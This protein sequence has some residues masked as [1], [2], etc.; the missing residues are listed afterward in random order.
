M[1][2]LEGRG[3]A[4]R[5][6]F[7]I[8]D[9]ESLEP[10]MRLGGGAHIISAVDQLTP[11][12]RVAV[13][14][15]HDQ[16]RAARRSIRFINAPGQ[17]Q[18][19][20]ELTTTLWREGINTFRSYRAA[21]ADRVTRFPVFLREESRHTG[22]KS[23]LLHDAASLRRA[24]LALRLRGYRLK[25]LLIVEFCDTKDAKGA[26]RKYSAFR[27][28]DAIVP[29]H[30][31]A[32]GDWMMKALRSSPDEEL[33]REEI[34]YIERNP[35]ETLLRRVFDLAHIQFG[36]IDY[37]VLNGVPQVWEINTNPTMGRNPGK[38]RKP[39]APAVQTLKDRARDVYHARLNPA[40]AALAQEGDA[41]SREIEVTIEPAVIAQA[42]AELAVI[43]RR[44]RLHTL[45]RDIYEHPRAATLRSMLRLVAPR[46]SASNLAY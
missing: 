24:I 14:A 36:R 5:D 12:Q 34:A 16:L 25:D 42:Q 29:A 38:A 45:A 1:L 13:T 35:H 37:G 26:Y 3:Q 41:T 11:A 44:R 28:G 30:M 43:A 32:G 40:F 4:L 19:R 18:L 7:D 20:Y 46:S 27:V 8:R 22:N 21:E 9:Y 6:A 10:R 31:M 17:V 2:Y 33:A 39:V 15:L 23:D